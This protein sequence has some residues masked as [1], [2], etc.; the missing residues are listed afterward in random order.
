[1]LVPITNTV[2]PSQSTQAPS[3][4]SNN[5]GIVPFQLSAFKEGMTSTNALVEPASNPE[6]LTI[7]AP[8]FIP[9]LILIYDRNQVSSTFKDSNSD[10]SDVPMPDGDNDS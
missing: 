3:S 1:M 9:A 7:A 6:T 4:G 5:Q 2:I 8:A 10:L